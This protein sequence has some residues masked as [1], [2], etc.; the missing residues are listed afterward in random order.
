MKHSEISNHIGHLVTLN[1]LG[2]LAM[3]SEFRPYLYPRPEFPFKFTIIKITRGGKVQ[4]QNSE[5]K[6]LSV[7]ALNLDLSFGHGVGCNTVECPSPDGPCPCSDE[8]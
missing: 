2:D 3:D 8:T 6:F 7:P 1:G 5:G 4:I